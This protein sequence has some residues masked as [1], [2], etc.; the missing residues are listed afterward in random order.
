MPDPV[1]EGGGAP[2]HLRA[3]IEHLIPHINAAYRTRTDPDSTASMGSSMGGL[4]AFYSAWTR[5]DVFGKAACLSSSFWWANR[6]AVR[7][8]QQGDCPSPRPTFYIDSGAALHEAERDVNQR[9]G[10]H[11]TRSMFRALTALGY[12]PGV[13]LHRLVFTGH[14][15]DAASW[16]SRVAIPLQLLFPAEGADAVDTE[17]PAP[18]SLERPTSP[19]P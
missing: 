19:A 2:E 18:A 12:T 4:F 5:G 1:H 13:D 8:V 3:I 11:H 15:H 10:F 17:V 6:Y 9:D 7:L 14:T 16:A